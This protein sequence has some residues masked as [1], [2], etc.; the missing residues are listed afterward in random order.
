MKKIQVVEGQM[1][2][3]ELFQSYVD[4]TEKEPEIKGITGELY[5]WQKAP[6]KAMRRVLLNVSAKEYLRQRAFFLFGEVGVGK[7]YIASYIA[8]DWVGHLI[9][10]APEETHEN[11]KKCLALFGVI[12]YQ[13]VDDIDYSVLRA[14]SPTELLI[15]VD[16]VHKVTKKIEHLKVL[17]RFVYLGSTLFGL[18]GTPF[19]KEANTFAKAALILANM[20]VPRLRRDQ[21]STYLR[22]IVPYHGI[23]L[24]KPTNEDTQA[25][26]IVHSKEVGIDMSPEQQAFYDFMV[27]RNIQVNSSEYQLA[28]AADEF[29]DFGDTDSFFTKR[30]TGKYF[31]GYKAKDHVK[32]QK[33][34]ALKRVLEDLSGKTLI[35]V[36]SKKALN[37]LKSEGLAAL[38]FE[39]KSKTE[40]LIHQFYEKEDVLVVCTTEVKEGI[41]LNEVSNIIWYQTPKHAVDFT[42]CN[43]RMLRGIPQEDTHKQVIQIYSRNTI[44]EKIA[45]RLSLV[46]SGNNISISAQSEESWEERLKQF[47]KNVKNM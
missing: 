36:N 24:S 43:G 10:L 31:I 16:E 21:V 20:D 3:M 7:T 38:E 12:N 17:E 33:L 27:A 4:V 15:I 19:A 32:N 44:Q 25:R 1:D 35:Y 34:E 26:Y 6:A 22:T 29:V 2:L 45:N 46:V 9:I 8:K 42:Q 11:W 28:K 13:L 18:T 23:S 37:F 39:D 30:D 41:N 14:C 40:Q 47:L 5:P